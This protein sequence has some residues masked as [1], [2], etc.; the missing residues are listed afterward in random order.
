MVPPGNGQ[1]LLRPF[2][3]TD[4]YDYWF[5][6]K[7]DVYIKIP[8]SGGYFILVDDEG[9]EKNANSSIIDLGMGATI[10]LY[11]MYNVEENSNFNPEKKYRVYYRLRSGG[12]EYLKS[13]NIYVDAIEGLLTY[14]E[15]QALDQQARQRANEIAEQNRL[16]D[17]NMAYSEAIKSNG[18]ERIIEYIKKYRR[19]NGFNNASYAEIAKRITGNTNI[20]F[21]EVITAPNP[22]AFDTT[23]VYYCNSLYVE[24]FIRGQIVAYISSFI[25]DD[26]NMIVIRNVP[27]ISKIGRFISNAYLKYTGVS[28]VA[29]TNGRIR[30]MA[31][32]DMFYHF[33][34]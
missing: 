4:R 18:V 7:S 30:E 6:F 11:R 32:F 22:Y 27:D 34:N 3:T 12:P 9:N 14:A 29:L 24:N 5:N 33:D 28:T 2:S 13:S 10:G 26:G 19:E 1:Y 17:M 21:K 31:T 8:S 23:T 16:R 15:A 25:I 20:L